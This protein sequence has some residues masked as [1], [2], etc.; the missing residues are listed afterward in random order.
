[1]PI[2]RR[3]AWLFSALLAATVCGCGQQDQIRTYRVL[4]HDALVKQNPGSDAHRR[5]AAQRAPDH[6]R[7]A[8]RFTT[9]ADWQKSDNDSFSSEAFEIRRGGATCRITIT[10]FPS[11]QAGLLKHVN[12]WQRQAAVPEVTMD[13]LASAVESIEVGGAAGIYV[14]AI[15]PKEAVLGCIVEHAGRRWFIKL[16]GDAALAK[17][18]E[19]TLRKFIDS[20]TFS[21]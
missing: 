7:V 6:L 19:P 11:D 16:R 10:D 9:P 20:V 15:G 2:R 21:H 13:Q 8:I 18:Q 5:P 14:K 17:E 1:V 12:R 3:R 4:K